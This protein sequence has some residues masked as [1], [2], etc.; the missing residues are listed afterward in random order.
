ME[1]RQKF[2]VTI[3]AEALKKS[4]NPFVVDQKW[5]R[6]LEKKDNNEVAVVI[7]EIIET[8]VEENE[9]PFVSSTE[10]N[11][12]GWHQLQSDITRNITIN[13]T[14][15]SADQ[16]E[17]ARQCDKN[18]FLQ[19]LSDIYHI[20]LQIISQLAQHYSQT[21]SCLI[22]ASIGAPFTNQDAFAVKQPQKIS[23]NIRIEGNNV[24]IEL[25][26]SNCP[27]FDTINETLLYAFND[28]IEGLFKLDPAKGFAL[29]HIRC[30]ELMSGIYFND[31][32]VIKKITEDATACLEKLREIKAESKKVAIPA[33]K[34]V[35][36]SKAEE[37]KAT[38]KSKT[39]DTTQKKSWR[40]KLPF[41]KAAAR[42]SA[43]KKP[44]ETKAPEKKSEPKKP[45][46][47]LFTM[48]TGNVY[49]EQT[50]TFTTESDPS[51]TC[52][53]H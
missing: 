24:F 25:R 34:T 37:S 41:F 14:G 48:Q 38:E 46:P 52:G 8:I 45:A 33:A 16:K 13:G 11:I 49:L 40:S 9:I 39:A 29:Q 2:D 42:F 43:H 7:N 17:Q 6:N 50:A 15:L 32:A 23:N 27:I 20:D 28:S 18:Q 10:P 26:A 36:K 1:S 35:K 19:L 5:P 4:T 53:N 51:T 3:T 30:S 22:A 44:A 12:P 21:P 47:A 31:P